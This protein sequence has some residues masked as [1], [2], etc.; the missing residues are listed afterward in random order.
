MTTLNW[1]FVGSE[2][3]TSGLLKKHELRAGYRAQFPDVYVPKDAR[4]TLRQRAVAGWLW[5]H[6][7]GVIAG[8]TAA[9]LHG[10]KWVD[11]TDPIE[12]VWQNARPPRGL[13]TYDMRLREREF[14]FYMGLPVTTPERTAFDIGRRGRLDLAV[15]RLDALA[16]ATGISAEKVRAVA[17]AHR[18]ARN[19]RQLAAAL[20]LHDPGAESPRET[21]LRLLV[22]RAG[23]RRPRTQIPVRSL[24]GRRQYYLDMG[25]EDLMLAVEYDGEQHRNDPHIYAND[26]QR[27]EDIAEVGWKRLRVVK[28]NTS[29]EV[30]R[31]LDRMWRSRLRS[32]REI[33]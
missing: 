5:S 8:L 32:D 15:A 24:D 22:I 19:L 4:P 27:S 29:G 13:V 21:W 2:A 25:W 31:R 18:G 6:R 16:N 10:A 33:S 23:Y 12:L 20:D 7:E 26:I 28:A 9:S 14:G 30:L 11:A 1:P 3:I 17:R